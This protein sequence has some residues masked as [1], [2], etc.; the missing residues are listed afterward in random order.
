MRARDFVLPLSALLL[1]V[2]LSDNKQK[3]PTWRLLFLIPILVLW[4]NLHGSV[5]LG[6]ALAA[7]YLVYRA[8]TAVNMG[9]RR[10]AAACAALALGVTLTPLANPYGVRIID[11]YREF[12][13][14]APMRLAAAEWGIAASLQRVLLRNCDPSFAGCPH[15]SYVL[16]SETRQCLR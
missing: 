16:L 1:F 6:A 8:V 10:D 3:R 7:A 4:A 13:G 14:N 5:L 15:S 12:V 11:Y 2:C 9:Y